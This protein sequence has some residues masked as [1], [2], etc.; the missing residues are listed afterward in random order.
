[1]P[2]EDGGGGDTPM[3]SFGRLIS[4]VDPPNPIQHMARR[5]DVAGNK[6]NT[7]LLSYVTGLC[8]GTK[9]RA[10]RA[11]TIIA[12]RWGLAYAVSNHRTS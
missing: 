4:T 7:Y 5:G 10:R 6:A 8:L 1:M 12:L 9:D 11:S 2:E 3:A